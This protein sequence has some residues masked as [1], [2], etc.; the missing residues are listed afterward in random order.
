MPQIQLPLFPNNVTHIT[1]ELAFIKADGKITYFNG[2][3]PVFS[4]AEEDLKTFRMITSQF[5][6]NGNATQ[7]DIARA[8][9]IT[10]ISV[11][12]AVKIYRTQGTKGFYQPRHVRGATVL[13]KAVLENV[14][15]QLINGVS[16][17]NIAKEFGLKENTLKKAIRAGRLSQPIKKTLPLLLAQPKVNVTKKI[18]RQHWDEVPQT[19]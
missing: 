2:S 5:C 16:V 10:K 3:M 12:R 4:H 17:S 13:T 8:F 11:K 6:V 18:V 9:G 19:Y 1:P 14:Q 15:E 7:A